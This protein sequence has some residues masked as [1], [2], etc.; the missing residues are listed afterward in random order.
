MRY[1]VDLVEKKIIVFGYDKKW[2]HYLSALEKVFVEG[3][4][5]EIEHK[6]IDYNQNDNV[7]LTGTTIGPGGY[8]TSPAF[9]SK[10]SNWDTNQILQ[11]VNQ[12]GTTVIDSSKKI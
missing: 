11:Y 2:K 10:T 4:K 3:N 6:A 1:T 8:T 5:F 9:I 12:I 7:I